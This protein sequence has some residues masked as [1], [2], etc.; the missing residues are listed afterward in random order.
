MSKVWKIE[1][2]A[3]ATTEVNAISF[4]WMDRLNGL[5]GWAAVIDY[6]GLSD[7]AAMEMIRFTWDSG[8]SESR[9]FFSGIIAEL[10]KLDNSRIFMVRGYGVA[11][12]L[13]KAPTGAIRTWLAETPYDIIQGT[14]PDGLVKDDAG[15]TILTYATSHHNAIKATATGSTMDFKSDR[16]R[17]LFNIA[18][19][20]DQARTA[21]VQGL[22]WF[23][24]D[25]AGTKE[26]HLVTRRTRASSYTAETFTVGSQ[27]VAVLEGKENIVGVQRVKAEAASVTSQAPVGTGTGTGNVAS[28][29][30][31][32]N[33]PTKAEATEVAKRVKTLRDFDTKVIRVMLGITDFDTEVGDD[34]V[35]DDT[36]GGTT[37][38][39]V[40]L[41]Y[42]SLSGLFTME[43]GRHGQSMQDLI[44]SLDARLEAVEQ[45][46][47][48][49]YEGAVLSTMPA[50][51]TNAALADAATLD[52]TLSFTDRNY[53][54]KADMG[55][56]FHVQASCDPGGTIDLELTMDSGGNV[57]Y[58]ARHTT[59]GTGVINL[60]FFISSAF[61]LTQGITS[62][63]TSA[64]ARLT[65][66]SGVNQN[67]VVQLH[68]AVVG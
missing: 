30:P 57:L 26:F 27:I 64:R 62:V 5:G 58:F 56:S 22:E 33:A 36:V 60:P 59:P 3:G 15:T 18:R 46:S 34:V 9:Q 63:F 48:Y 2:V 53:D 21:T 54:P 1:H 45:G 49:L 6:T 41:G 24:K 66:R 17:L 47:Q 38:R 25:N 20:A 37:L 7:P 12:P 43:I 16:G 42:D 35:F 52:A 68:A 10:Q 23:G 14:T 39:C 44:G 19:L 13:A 31:A 28:V 55:I 4:A 65:N 29:V 50:V 32:K 51:G 67:A 40:G 61:L 11:Y 8:G